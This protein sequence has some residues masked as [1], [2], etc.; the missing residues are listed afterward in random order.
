MGS[1]DSKFE[2]GHI[3]LQLDKDFYLSGHDVTGSIHINLTESFPSESLTIHIKG[4]EK[5]KWES[6]SGKDRSYHHSDR[7]IINHRV[8]IFSFNDGIAYAG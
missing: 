3:I 1:G 6:G 7:K 8:Q 4:K 5:C 2:H